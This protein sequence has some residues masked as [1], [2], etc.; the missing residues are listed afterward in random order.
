[1]YLSEAQT[2]L[3]TYRGQWNVDELSS[4]LK[5]GQHGQ[6]IK[7]LIRQLEAPPGAPVSEPEK[8]TLGKTD[9]AL[10]R[11]LQ[12]ISKTQPIKRSVI[13][14]EIEEAI[15]QQGNY[16]KWNL[17]S[18][19]DDKSNITWE[20]VKPLLWR[21]E[22]LADLE[23]NLPT[24]LQQ[25][26]QPQLAT[27]FL[28]NAVPTPGAGQGAMQIKNRRQRKQPAPPAVSTSQATVKSQVAAD[29]TETDSE[30]ETKRLL[31]DQ[32]RPTS[33]AATP[34]QTHGT[35]RQRKSL[36][37]SC[38]DRLLGLCGYQGTE[39]QASQPTQPTAPGIAPV[40]Q[41]MAR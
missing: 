19:K 21:Q 7:A 31:A 13:K 36:L 26:A 28:G 9:R 11:A 2:S 22:R 34:T 8:D 18:F 32:R 1:M 4:P 10:A 3:E 12:A 20:S 33:M 25:N 41:S 40:S 16:I 14:S 37:E 38:K 39:P 29:T 5:T 15:K 27:S 24:L 30:A 6:E 17:L 23:R 35:I